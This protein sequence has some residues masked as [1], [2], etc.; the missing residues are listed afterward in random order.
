MDKNKNSYIFIYSIILVVLVAGAL[1]IVSIVLQPRQRKNFE[2][3]QK[4]NIL[5]ALNMN[6]ETKDVEN[7]YD[8]VIS[9]VIYLDSLGNVVERQKGAMPIYVADIEESSKYVFPLF[10]KGLWGPIWGYMTLNDDMN[11]V[12]GVYFDHKSETSGLGAEIATE[13]FQAQYCDKHIFDESGEFV[14]VNTVKGGAKTDNEVDAISGGTITSTSVNTMIKSCLN[15]YMSFIN[16][17]K[18]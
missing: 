15:K 11:T 13:W 14:S 6:V 8:K 17:S 10:G 7:T 18:K 3:E 4:K 1:S 9:D 5:S 16:K 2:V 12:Y